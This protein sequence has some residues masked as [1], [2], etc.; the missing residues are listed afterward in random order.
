[1]SENIQLKFEFTPKQSNIQGFL[2]MEEA[3]IISEMKSID[4]C[5]NF[6]TETIEKMNVEVIPKYIV[7]NNLEDGY[8]RVKCLS[9]IKVN[10]QR[11]VRVDLLNNTYVIIPKDHFEYT[12]KNFN[13]EDLQCMNRSQTMM[14]HFMLYVNRGIYFHIYNF[15]Y[16]P[17]LY[18]QNS[19]FKDLPAFGRGTFKVLLFSVVK[20]DGKDRIRVDVNPIHHFILPEKNKEVTIDRLGWWNKQ[21]L[22]VDIYSN[23]VDFIAE[24]N[25]PYDEPK[26]ICA[27][28]E[29]NEKEDESEN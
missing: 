4:I 2:I 7:L 11:R 26:M 21:R 27:L 29:A 3:N 19:I 6:I 18:Y 13:E 16:D 24:E 10:K 1:M 28:Q 15:I 22:M 17:P 5:G 23:Q 8:H 25:F 12:E 9:F 14:L 20:K